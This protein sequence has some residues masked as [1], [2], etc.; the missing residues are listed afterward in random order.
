MRKAKVINNG[1][2]S[3]VEVLSIEADGDYKYCI[4]KFPDN[5]LYEVDIKGLEYID[6]PNQLS[7]ETQA[8]AILFEGQCRLQAMLADNKQSEMDNC[9]Y[10]RYNYEDF[11]NLQAEIQRRINDLNKEK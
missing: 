3:I 7:T 9:S 6:E 5:R 8:Q 11:D 4:C 1:N 2:E 10:F